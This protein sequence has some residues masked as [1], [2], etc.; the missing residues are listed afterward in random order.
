MG[1]IYVVAP[2][3]DEVAE[4]LRSES[5]VVPHEASKGP[6]FRDIQ[7]AISG[8]DGYSVE[9]D[10]YAVGASWDAQIASRVD[11]YS[12]TRAT[13]QKLAPADHPQS[14]A[15]HKGSPELVVAIVLRLSQACGPLVLF[16]D[17]G[18]SPLVV[19]PQDDIENL[20]KFWNL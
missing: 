9:S 17:S 6:L 20:L 8:L 12:W 7:D 11:Q 15:F 10:P 16:T 14:L 13:V 4:F 3:D 18:D 1:V 19:S 2:I 5:I